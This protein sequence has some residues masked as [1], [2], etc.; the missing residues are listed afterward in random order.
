[1]A[2]CDWFLQSVREVKHFLNN[3]IVSDEAIFSLNSEVNTH[4]VIQYKKHGEG[5]TDDHYVGQE[6]RVLE[7]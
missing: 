3:L 7:K 4:N 1:M 5:Y 2:F 6:H